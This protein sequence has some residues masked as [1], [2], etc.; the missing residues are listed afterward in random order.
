MLTLGQLLWRYGWD[1]YRMQSFVDKM[2]ANFRR[3]YDH[4]AKGHAFTR[5]EE[6]LSSMSPDF[7]RLLQSTLADEL[8]SSGF[9]EPLIQELVNAGIRCNYGQSTSIHAFVGLVSMAGMQSGLWSVHGGNRLVPERLVNSS[10]A[11][12][13]HADVHTIV[14]QKKLKKSDGDL[15]L[16]QLQ[17][18][19]L[20]GSEKYLSR[21]YDVVVIAAPLHDDI[22]GIQFENFPRPVVKPPQPFHK[23]VTTFVSGWPNA[24]MFGYRTVGNLPEQVLTSKDG[25]FF[26]SLGRQTAVDFKHGE[27]ASTVADA[28]KATG[29]EATPTA[30]GSSKSDNLKDHSTTVPV[31]KVFSPA[32]L[33]KEQLNSLFLSYN[34]VRVVDWAAYP[35]YSS[36]AK[37]LPGF[38]LGMQIYYTNAMEMASSTMETCVISGRNVALLAYNR[39][40]D[41]DDKIDD[42][43]DGRE[44]ED[45]VRNEL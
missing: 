29:D 1:I 40:F 22:A 31:W 41:R 19:E 44:L 33:T 7:L 11:T 34:D 24:T 12:L 15:R 37:D 5:V 25:L 9:S 28:D 43:N 20:D 35:K 36:N 26:N 16:Y 17:S 23:T 27:K 39:W 14:R 10:E 3:I 38:E 32:V 2:F 42:I 45:K 18:F 21:S 4:Q 8:R 6:L 13:L 30:D